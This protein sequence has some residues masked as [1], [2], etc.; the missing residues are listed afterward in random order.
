VVLSY[1]A[2]I[3]KPLETISTTVGALQERF[4]ALEMAFQLLD[5]EPRV[6]N[7]PEAVD[8]ESVRGEIAYE[9]VSFTYDGRERTLKGV[10]F[11][12][13]PGEVVGIVGPTG[14]G[15]STLVSLLPRFYDPGRGRITLDGV[16]LRRIRLESL[17]DHIS[18]VLQDSLLFKGSI[19]E[20]IRY[21]RL[22][23][24]MDAV[25]EAARAANAHD[26]ISALPKGYDTP[27]G[28]KGVGLSGG[29]RQRIAVARAFLKDAPILILD[30]PTSSIDSRT[31]GVILDALERLMEGRTTLMIAH[32]LSTIRHAAH[33]LVIDGGQV[34]EQGSPGE[35]LR[36]DGLYRRLWEAQTRPSRNGAG[37]DAHGGDDPDDEPDER[38]V[39]AGGRAAR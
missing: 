16:D 11:R 33:V 8:L 24:D 18:I 32:R 29:E 31:E 14:A 5:T 25:F 15:K 35:L 36:H 28:E 37:A 21:G 4:I 38:L 23:A 26:F 19:A 7:H 2:S 10:N 22:D 34:I 1:V 39:G 17:R 9:D 13:R 12:A 6:R 30:E 20:N 3:Y 27:V